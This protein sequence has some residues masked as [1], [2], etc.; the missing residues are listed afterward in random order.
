MTI[1][2]K[3]IKKLSQPQI[4][5]YGNIKRKLKNDV[6]KPEHIKQYSWKNEKNITINDLHEIMTKKSVEMK[7]NGFTGQYQ[8]SIN[9]PE[10]P[11]TGYLTD[12]GK[13]ADIWNPDEYESDKIVNNESQT[14]QLQRWYDD[15]NAKITDFTVWF[16]YKP[17]AGGC[18]GE[19]NDCL[20]NCVY[21]SFGGNL[22]INSRTD[23]P[24]FKMPYKLKKYLGI[25]RKAKVNTDE[26]IDRIE[27]KL[28]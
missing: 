24:I 14:S 15:G 26:H 5:D 19:F 10:G 21:N 6:L 9:T 28:N 12:I 3:N 17:N 23:E 18:D 16:V 20:W 11:R 7:K 27:Q 4:I 1:K 2:A 13:S 22:P 8:I 25:D